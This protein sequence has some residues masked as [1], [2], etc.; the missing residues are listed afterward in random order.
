MVNLLVLDEAGQIPPELGAVAC[1]IAEKA[2]V[3]GDTFQLEPVWDIPKHVDIA[4][5]EKYKLLKQNSAEDYEK[6]RRRGILASSGNM[7]DLAI[8]ASRRE[9]DSGKGVFLSE[10]RR[11]VP[12]LVAYCNALAYRGRL[13]AKRE[14][15]KKR[16]LPAFGWAHIGGTCRKVGTSRLNQ[17]EADEIVRWIG[18]RR[19]EF[20]AA[21]RLPISKIVAVITPFAAQRRALSS[22][23]GQKYPKLVVG[24]V[25]ALQ[26]AECPIV[27]FSSVYD[28]SYTGPLFFDRGP[29]ML[30]V[31]VSRAKDS[32]LVFGDMGIFESEG[33]SPSSLLRRFLFADDRNEILDIEPVKRIEDKKEEVLQR[34]STL[35]EHQAALDQALSS[36]KR[37]VMIVSPTISQIA[38]EHD[39]I[40]QK[41]KAA[42]QRGIKVKVYTDHDLNRD[43]G[44]LVENAK[45]GRA[46]LQSAGAQLIE[47]ARI[48]NKSLAVDKHTL[49]EGSFNW[50]SAVR[51][52]SS[53]HQKL[54]ISFCY[55]GKQAEQAIA[56]LHEDME[57]RSRASL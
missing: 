3:V 42:V 12:E 32:F 18:S 57:F 9:D 1:S 27:I 19:K 22:A 31:A 46:S 21:Y 35:G 7:M 40:D 52:R 15:L 33:S 20:E 55:R 14:G 50:L 8:G 51:N 16:I 30:N 48:H 39:A 49:I 23:L 5:A 11:S 44:E 43:K 45:L 17:E 37:E 4:N 25:N 13:Q 54:E 6:L 38:I 36:A 47:V 29:N 34:F 53:R 56:A 41:I 28:Q 2:L 10:H 24:T 26:G